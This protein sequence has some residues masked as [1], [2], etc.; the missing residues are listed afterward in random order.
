MRPYV[1][2][3]LRNPLLWILPAV[4]LPLL[5]AVGAIMT[6]GQARVEASLWTQVSPLIDTS[7]GT[8]KP[9]A[10]VE[11]DTFNERLSTES[12]RFSII[13]AAGLDDRVKNGTWPGESG[14]GNLLAKFPLT[15]PLAGFFGASSSG[16]VEANR[17]R[18]LAAVKASLVAEARGNN[19]LYVVY[20]GDSADTGVALVS[21]AISA[22][23]KESVG[24][25][26][27]QASAVLN[28]YAQ[29]VAEREQALEQADADLRAFEAEHPAA[30]GAP[31]AASEAQQ[32]AQYQSI[33]NIRLSQYELAMNRQG[34]AQVRAQASLTTSDNN[35]Q[36][37]D[38][39][40]TARGLALNLRR[41]AMLTFVGIVFGF[42]LGGLLIV[43]RTWFDETVRRREDVKGLF[44][45]DVL[46]VL[47]NVKKGGE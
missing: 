34:D 19:V 29:Q 3:A 46:A 22:Y 9:P 41:A 21:A 43:L 27:A 36:L 12:F 15:K 25:S 14:V 23:Q 8:L 38:E 4:L 13:T 37:V 6:G 16:D 18:A 28:F 35:F 24:Q 39:A 26:S 33:Y 42:G 17:N 20:T 44:G 10:Q 47:P 31:R 11:A 32:L 2:T 30:V 40:H 5:V 7:A 45:L 1:M